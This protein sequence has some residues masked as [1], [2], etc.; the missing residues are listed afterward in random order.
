[1]A[2]ILGALLLAWSLYLGFVEHFSHFYELTLLGLL[3][4]LMPWI[5]H[6]LTFGIALKFYLACVVVAL[7]GDLGIVLGLTHLW[8]YTYTHFWE[9]ALLY[10]FIYPAG[11]FVMLA[12]YLIVKPYFLPKINKRINFEIFFICLA[13]LVGGAVLVELPL[14]DALS[15]TLW[16]LL[17]TGTIAVALG[18]PAALYSEKLYRAS[19]L[20]DLLSNPV[21]CVLATIVATYPNFF[22]HEFPNIYARQWV[23]TIP[24]ETFADAMISAIPLFIWLTWPF[25]T[26]ISVSL[27]YAVAGDQ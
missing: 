25:L 16:N 22:L 14:R 26:I 12:S 15:E 19:F 11:G 13:V 24:P 8:H 3:F 10:L 27:F 17:F 18:I 4:I 5:T 1:M 2:T 9:Y 7:L 21:G 23:Y 20:R 6:R